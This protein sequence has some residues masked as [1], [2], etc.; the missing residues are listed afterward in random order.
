MIQYE[1]P[2]RWLDFDA[3]RV[4]PAL[5]EAWVNVRSLQ[6]MPYQR[7][8]VEGLQEIELK[9]EVAGTSR[10]EG[11]E[12]TDRELEEALRES[13]EALLTRSQRQAHAAAMTYRWIA[14]VPDDRSLDGDLVREIHRRIVAGADDDHCPPGRLR[15]RG[16]NVI[17]GSPR[18]RGAEGGEECETAFRRFAEALQQDYRGHDPLLQALAAHYHLAAMHPFLDGNGRTARALEALLLRRA[19]LREACFIPMSNYYYDEK[20]SY[21]EALAAARAGNHDLTPFLL[22]ALEGVRIQS[23]RVL[24]EARRQVSKAV[25]RDVM[26]QLFTRLK[27]P[28]RRVMVERQLEILKLLLDH[29]SMELDALVERIRAHY[30][31]LRNPL[32]AVRRD[33]VELAHLEAISMQRAGQ[34]SIRLTIRLEW[35]MEIT[36]TE[37]FKRVKQLPKARSHPFL[38]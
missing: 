38:P 24:S 16:Q 20:P 36:E 22:F 21:L 10:I 19:G 5:F 4:V 13:P 37:F 29:E 1:I 31:R 17:F 33:L 12:F 6:S 25:F 30:G 23:L 14:T 2:R 8:W 26:Y 11:A 32:K 28:R 18:H 27:A 9:R 15:E 35:P 7:S 34:G 3:E